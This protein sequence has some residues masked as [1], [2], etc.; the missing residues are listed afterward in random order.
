MSQTISIPA[1]YKNITD[2]QMT[3]SG[4]ST[5]IT[6]L[7]PVT[8]NVKGRPENIFVQALAGNTGKVYLRQGTATVGGSGLELAPGA[9]INLP[10][11]DATTWQA[12]GTASDKLNIVY[13]S[14]TN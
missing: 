13:M 2:K 11:N 8:D 5:V 3:I 1:H 6:Q 12:I 10:S 9:N 14:G 4:T 7:T